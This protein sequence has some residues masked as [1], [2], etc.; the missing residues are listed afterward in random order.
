MN[1]H[2]S[3]ATKTNGSAVLAEVTE[4]KAETPKVPK[5]KLVR[6][7]FTIPKAEYTTL[8]ELRQRATRLAAPAKKS[9]LLRAGIELLK[10]LSDQAFLAALAAVPNLKTGRP[11]KEGEEESDE[12]AAKTGKKIIDK[13]A[14]RPAAK[15]AAKGAANAAAKGG[16]K[17]AAKG[18]AKKAGAGNKGAAG[19]AAKNPARQAARKAAKQAAGNE[20]KAARQAAKAARQA[21]KA[22]ED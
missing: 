20:P 22:E 8:N 1:E 5:A 19:N 10:G 21:A 6:D 17:A 2:D 9:E 14:A 15:N 16:P 18:G 4:Q 12:P 13:I 7:S 3:S 11:K